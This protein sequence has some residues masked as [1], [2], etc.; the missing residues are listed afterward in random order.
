[1]VPS[2]LTVKF[3]FVKPSAASLAVNVVPSIVVS[4]SPVPVVSP[5]NDAGS[6]TAFTVTFITWLS[7][8]PSSSVIVTVKLSLPLK[9]VFG[10]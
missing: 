4:S 2:A 5:P 6:L 3:G 9:F 8:L 10:V 1:M 7:T